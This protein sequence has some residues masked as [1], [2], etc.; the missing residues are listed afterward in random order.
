MTEVQEN[1][2]INII[3]GK[4]K[5][6]MKRDSV[7][8]VLPT[9]YIIVFL[10]IPLISIFILG[11]KDENG[12]T[13]KYYYQ[14]FTNKVYLKMLL[15][16]IRTSFIV[17]LCTLVMAYP[18]AYVMTICS[19]RTRAIFNIF[20]MVPFW[21]SILV[22]TYSWIVLLQSKGVVNS[23]L[24]QLGIINEPIKLL[25]NPISV[26][27]GMTNALLPYMILSLYS[28]LDGID[29]NLILAAKSLGAN[30]FTAF[31]KVYFPLSINGVAN[32]CI[33]VFVMAMG[34]YITPALLGGEDTP[35]I[36]QF[37]STQVSKLLNWQVGSAAAFVLLIITMILLNISNRVLSTKNS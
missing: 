19:K 5:T 21:S 2:N 24:I 9:L 32:G 3:G 13:L 37:I 28:V 10:I 20:V 22:R 6:R 11:I 7:L 29:R 23:M 27:I 4:V 17:T 34:Y 14:I 36:S 15:L 12:F 18:I 8:L 1:S 26:T 35:M 30:K 33:M 16:T 25:Y 31:F